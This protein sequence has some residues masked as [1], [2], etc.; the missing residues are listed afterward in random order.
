MGTRVFRE[1]FEMWSTDNFSGRGGGGMFDLCNNLWSFFTNAAI[2]F[3]DFFC[4]FAEICI[5]ALCNG[6]LTNMMM[7]G[8]VYLI[9]R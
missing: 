3:V 2:F 9:N 7:G 8:I 5:Y 4:F 6:R 1:I